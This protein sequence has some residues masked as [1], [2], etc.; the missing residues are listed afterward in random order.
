MARAALTRIEES[1]E[2]ET[3]TLNTGWNLTHVTGS[4]WPLSSDLHKKHAP[5]YVQSMRKQPPRKKKNVWARGLRM[6]SNC[7]RARLNDKPV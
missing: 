1:S 6:H 7:A 3:N 4:R 2:P 5:A